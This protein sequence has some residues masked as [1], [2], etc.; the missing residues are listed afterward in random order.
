MILLKALETALRQ[1]G[2]GAIGKIPEKMKEVIKLN[3][4]I[5]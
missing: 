2:K 3:V 4:Q 5:N 1:L